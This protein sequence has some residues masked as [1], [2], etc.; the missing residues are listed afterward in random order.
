MRRASGSRIAEQ[1][2]PTNPAQHPVAATRALPRALPVSKLKQSLI[3]EETHSGL[4]L[5]DPPPF[6]AANPGPLHAGFLQK[7]PDHSRPYCTQDAQG[8]RERPA[9]KSAAR[10]SGEC[11]S[12]S[13]VRKRAGHR[14]LVSA[15]PSPRSSCR[16]P[17]GE[18]GRMQAGPAE[19]R[20][21]G[22]AEVPSAF[23][24]GL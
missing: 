12:R 22:T 13:R 20:G 8:S 6:R 24:T 19:K 18:S 21:S 5:Q 4:R 1:A 2:A 9:L 11:L 23:Y 3:P 14:E 10:D 16:D 17:K 15:A 7:S